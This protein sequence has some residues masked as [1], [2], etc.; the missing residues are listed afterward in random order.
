M[1]KEYP[2]NFIEFQ[3]VWET[4]GIK[5]RCFAWIKLAK[6]CSRNFYFS[7]IFCLHYFSGH[8]VRENVL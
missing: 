3:K 7:N 1:V 5:L 6:L 2:L 8:I 4:R